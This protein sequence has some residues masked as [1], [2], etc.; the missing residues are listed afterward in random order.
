M[1]SPKQSLWSSTDEPKKYERKGEV[2]NPSCLQFPLIHFSCFP[3]YEHVQTQVVTD[4]WITKN[5]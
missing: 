4:L 5:D 3:L 1:L 2:K